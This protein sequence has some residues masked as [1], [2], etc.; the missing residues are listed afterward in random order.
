MVLWQREYVK[1][2]RPGPPVIL[3]CEAFQPSAPADRNGD[4]LFSVDAIGDRI[5]VNPA[6]RLELPQQLAGARVVG[7]ELARRLTRENQVAA[8]AE[9]RRHHWLLAA[10]CPDLPA[11][12]R[13]ERFDFAPAFL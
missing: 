3:W 8:R 4:V 10:P 7:I 9:H 13:I 1:C 6:A 11:R 2:R 12:A 5:P